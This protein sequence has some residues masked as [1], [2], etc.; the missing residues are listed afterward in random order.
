MRRPLALL[1]ALVALLVIPAGPAAAHVGGGPQPSNFAS[2]ITSASS[3]APGLSVTLTEDGE[4][5]RVTTEGTGELMVPGYS[6]EPYLLLDESGVRRNV[7]SPAT[8]LN[9]SLSGDTELPPEADPTAAPEWAFV[10]STPT[11]EWHDH[12]THWMG[13]VLPPQVQTDPASPH[14]I[15]E[16]SVPLEYDGRLLTVT[17]T[18]TWYPPPSSLP[19]TFLVVGLVVLG[20]AVAGRTSWQRPLVGLLGVAVLGEIVHLAV[21]PVPAESP[22]YAVTA[23]AL[24]VVIAL[25]L[26]WAAWRSARAGTGTVVFTAGIAAWLV[27]LQGLSDITVLWNS[28]LAATGPAWL[29]RLAVTVTVGLGFGVA[30]ATV[31]LLTRGRATTAPASL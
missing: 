14:L 15:A 16:W 21:S 31:R 6:D 7:R 1:A 22:V 28:Q 24:P 26:T 27:L 17:G 20:V 11:Y 2:V 23:G 5:L 8:Y 30:L 9:V 18:L 3:P 25:L 13:S 19:S 12:R 4:Q 29:T 10:S